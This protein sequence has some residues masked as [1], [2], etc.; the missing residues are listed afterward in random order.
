MGLNYV[1]LFNGMGCGDLAFK[2][3]DIKIDKYYGSEIDKYANGVAKYNNP[4]MIEL[5]DVRNIDVKRDIPDKIDML[6]GGS[7]C[8]TKGCKI[9]CNNEYKN[10]EDI[11]VGDYVLTH[12]NRFKKVLKIGSSIKDTK[13]IQISG[14]KDIETT[15]NH[16]FYIKQVTGFNYNPVDWIPIKNINMG[17]LCGTI[18]HNDINWNKVT[19]IY[20][21]KQQQQVYNLEVEE[22]NSYTA[23]N[24]IVHNCQSFSFAGKRNGMST[25]DNLEILSLE[26]YLELKEEKFEFEGQSYLFWEY[27]RI[28]KELKPKYFLLENVKMSK[29]WEK[30]LSNAIGVEPIMIN[31]AL[32]TA[33]NRKR[34][35]WCGKLNTEQ[36]SSGQLSL[37]E[38]KQINK[39]IRCEIV[40]P[41]DKGIL[42]KDI[43]DYKCSEELSNNE[44]NYMNR[45]SKKFSN[46]KK[47]LDVY[48]KRE[49]EKAGYLTKSMHKGVPHGVIEINTVNVDKA[50]TIKKNY[51]KMSTAN[52]IH[53]GG[54]HHATG[55]IV[56]S[57]IINVKK[58]STDKS[59]FFEQNCY[60]ENSPK[61]I[62]SNVKIGKYTKIDKP[63]N[64]LCKQAGTADDINGHD[65]LK[66]VYSHDGK[67]PCLTGGKGGNLEP[68]IILGGAQRGRY[69][70]QGKIEQQ[71]ELNNTEKSNCLTTVSK[72]CLIITKEQNN[73]KD[74]NGKSSTLTKNPQR[75]TIDNANLIPVAGR[76]G[77]RKLDK[78]GKRN[79]KLN[80]SNTKI[81]EINENKNKIGTITT[82]QTDNL[83]IDEN[84]VN[85]QI[86]HHKKEN[87][88]YRKLTP[89]EC[90]KLQAV[91]ENGTLNGIMLNKKGIEEQV[92]ISN[93]RRYMMLGNG[94]TVS[95]IAHIFKEIGL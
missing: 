40:Q 46:G 12:K 13:I 6:I 86:K 29:K 71:I 14:L 36:L 41:K 9:R 67:G 92:I 84:T 11:K 80:I 47:R 59:W 23:N 62:T 45:S 48:L 51:Y 66:R 74:L 85:D 70:E 95:V 17:S 25:K 91:P 32:L 53:P 87:L 56:N 65:I 60:D 72:D 7:P 82:V 77:S 35:Y 31:S 28:L 54:T 90:E 37:F 81:I 2:L 42:L 20:D 75:A 8:F 24:A 27:M 15:A 19:A 50:Q 4:N 57:N 49:E 63:N 55:V 16:P 5:G 43:I 30:I 93:S 39:Y 10:I 22:D 88:T 89:L 78:S 76:M 38:P 61:I 69:N 1:S 21:S 3:A 44:M 73:K 79:D 64:G 94:W 34:L 68:K 18:Q 52:F 83:L 26:H 33:Q 58:G